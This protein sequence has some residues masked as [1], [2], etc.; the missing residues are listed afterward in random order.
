MRSP[1]S[2]ISDLRLI[3]DYDPKRPLIE[4]TIT[5]DDMEMW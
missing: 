2:Q 1:V 4:I 5:E 3:R